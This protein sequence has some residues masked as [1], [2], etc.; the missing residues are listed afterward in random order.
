MWVSSYGR[1]DLRLR[2]DG[3]GVCD[4][5]QTQSQHLVWRRFTESASSIGV[6]TSS[7]LRRSFPG[8]ELSSKP[9]FWLE[10]FMCYH[11]PSCTFSPNQTSFCNQALIQPKFW[12]ITKYRDLRTLS[13]ALLSATPDTSA[14]TVQNSSLRICQAIQVSTMRVQFL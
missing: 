2:E 9:G 8:P 14:K 4:R 5:S 11:S 12:R 3:E 6:A 7:R 1:I 10:G 13:K